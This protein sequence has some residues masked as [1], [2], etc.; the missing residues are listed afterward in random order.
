[1]RIEPPPSLPCAIGMMLAATATAAPPL[2]PPDERVRSHG[3]RVGPPFCTASVVGAM[4]NSGTVV[5][6]KDKKP[7][8]MKRVFRVDSMSDFMPVK[9]R[10]P[11]LE[12]REVEARPE[13]FKRNGN[14]RKVPFFSTFAAC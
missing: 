12:S 7:S 8:A 3:L 6:P 1:M 2:E 4:Q 5:R 11:V 9:S 13:S 10:E 14:A